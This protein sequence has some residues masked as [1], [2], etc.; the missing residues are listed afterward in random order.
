MGGYIDRVE[1]AKPGSYDRADW[2]GA[3]GVLFGTLAALISLVPVVGIQMFWVPASAAI[4][5]GS[6][7]LWR[8]RDGRGVRNLS[9]WALGLGVS[10]FVVSAGYLLAW[11][12]IRTLADQC[13]A[14][15]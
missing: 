1:S 13:L 6:V 12:A 8:S 2:F 5:L 9:P 11:L 14:P 15:C 3:V 4:A 10:G 7:G